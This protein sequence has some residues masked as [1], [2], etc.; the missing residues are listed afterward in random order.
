MKENQSVE[1]K[2]LDIVIDKTANWKE[3]AKDCV[4]FANSRGGFILIGIA[5]SEILPPA[6]QVIDADLP[7]RIK[8][9]ITE[10]SVNVGVEAKIKTAENGGEYIEVEVLFSS[11]TI[12]A[13][14]DGKYY[15]RSDDT[16]VPLLPYELS[17]L[18]TDKPSFI[19]ETR[20]TKISV[21]E[22]DPAKFDLFKKDI[23]ISTR[24]SNHIRQMR[25]YLSIIS[26]LKRVS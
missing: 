11:S 12:A 20:K 5:D 24:V 16:C 7:F 4:C 17:R 21:A 2:R 10:N 14:T 22:I 23:Q 19:W 1:K 3:I 9:K 13:T 8:K 25:N 6:T 18:F 26:L 15:Y